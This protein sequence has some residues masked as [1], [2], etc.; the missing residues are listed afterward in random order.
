M[1]GNGFMILSFSS[2]LGAFCDRGPESAGRKRQGKK[3]FLPALKGEKLFGRKLASL[4]SQFAASADHTQPQLQLITQSFRRF[5][6]RF[7]A[8]TYTGFPGVEMVSVSF[9]M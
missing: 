1:K 2:P 3:C 5:M 6:Y 9:M 8:G 4:S 7:C